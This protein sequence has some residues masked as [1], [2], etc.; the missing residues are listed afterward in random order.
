MNRIE[1]NHRFQCNDYFRTK[2]Y[3]S[4]KYLTRELKIDFVFAR[5]SISLILKTLSNSELQESFWCR[6]R[7]RERD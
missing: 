7:K 3:F 6:L 4:R 2:N 1:W 5:N